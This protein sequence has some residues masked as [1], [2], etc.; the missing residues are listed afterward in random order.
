VSLL[1]RVT[2]SSAV[3][4]RTA[5]R[6][7][8]YRFKRAKNL[9]CNIIY[10]ATLKVIAVAKVKANIVIHISSRVRRSAVGPLIVAPA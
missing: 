5:S 9:V 6:P 8:F 2:R 3:L 1:S 4:L 10:D 7:P